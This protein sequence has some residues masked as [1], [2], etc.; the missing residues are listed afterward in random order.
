MKDGPIKVPTKYIALALYIALTLRLV[1][2]QDCLVQPEDQK[3]Q[4]NIKLF[5]IKYTMKYLMIKSKKRHTW[6]FFWGLE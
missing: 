6:I 1:H 4:D 2:R 3:I 5:I